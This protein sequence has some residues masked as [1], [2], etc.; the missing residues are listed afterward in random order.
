ML[1]NKKKQNCSHP[2]ACMQY[3]RNH[4]D[5]IDAGVNVLE[6]IFRMRTIQCKRK[7]NIIRGL[8]EKLA[9]LQLSLVYKVLSYGLSDGRRRSGAWR[10]F[11]YIY[12]CRRHLGTAQK[13]FMKYQNFPNDV[14][15]E[16]V[17]CL[18]TENFFWN[19]W[20]W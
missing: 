11:N 5:M 1:T 9:I 12:Y 8:N 4:K 2:W 3:K 15:P 19:C 6:W 7:I 20:N 13:V 18:M 14:N 17:F 16:S 10:W